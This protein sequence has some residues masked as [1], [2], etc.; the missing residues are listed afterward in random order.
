MIVAQVE[1]RIEAT[2]DRNG[3]QIC[4]FSC[5]YNAFLLL[6]NRF[7]KQTRSH[8]SKSSPKKNTPDSETVYIKSHVVLAPTFYTVSMHYAFCKKLG[9]LACF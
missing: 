8:A 7:C 6:L 9:K 2:R 5:L 1:S 4:L 3:Y